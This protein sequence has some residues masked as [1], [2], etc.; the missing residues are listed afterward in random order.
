LSLEAIKSISEAEDE[1]R[2]AKLRAQ[3]NAR[4]MA[5]DAEKA[6]KDAVASSIA[7]AESEIAEFLRAAD[8]KAAEQA[9]ELASTTANRQATLRARAE[10]RTDKAA[11]LIIE[12]IVNA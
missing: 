6:G 9:V 10:S 5:E 1:A 3:Q 12:R 4:V 2:Q 11:A 7:R 8:Q